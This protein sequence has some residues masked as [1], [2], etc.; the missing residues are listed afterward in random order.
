MTGVY[1]SSCMTRSEKPSTAWP[2]R[3]DSTPQWRTYSP[4]QSPRA[5]SEPRG[6]RAEAARDV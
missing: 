5:Q 2:I 4:L 1:D 3:H 6:R